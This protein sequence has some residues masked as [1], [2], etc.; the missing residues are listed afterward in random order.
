MTADH[1]LLKEM[2]KAY[3]FYKRGEV[4]NFD[5]AMGRIMM[6]FCGNARR[7]LRNMENAFDEA[8]EGR[9][10]GDSVSVPKPGGGD[11]P[12]TIGD[13]PLPDSGKTV[14]KP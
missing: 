4:D 5:V 11:V 2:K 9:P 14:R 3:A 13:S 6:S 8:I 1:A 12:E 10:P 7:V